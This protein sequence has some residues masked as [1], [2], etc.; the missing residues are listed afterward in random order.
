[1]NE[2]SKTTSNSP[3]EVLSKV[4]EENEDRVLEIEILGSEVPLP[5]GQLI[6]EDGSSIGIHK[7]VLAKAFIEASLI[8]LK[9]NDSISKHVRH[10]SIAV[11]FF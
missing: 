7:K 9:R 8:F 1:M 6:L 5:E 2:A 3:F 4:F 10:F 11:R